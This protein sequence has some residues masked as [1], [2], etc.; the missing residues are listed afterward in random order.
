MKNRLLF[1]SVVLI[2]GLAL[3]AGALS[4]A[5]AMSME[6]APGALTNDQPIK[7]EKEWTGPAIYSPTGLVA[8][9]VYDPDYNLVPG[10]EV[11]FYTRDW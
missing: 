7:I 5:S 1:L 9:M 6:T 8:G 3:S 2:L 4:V 10:S 11:S